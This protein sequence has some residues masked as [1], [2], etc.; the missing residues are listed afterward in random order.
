MFLFPRRNQPA[1]VLVAALVGTAVLGTAAR[2]DAQPINPQ[3]FKKK[4]EAARKEA[5]VVARARVLATACT[6]AAAGKGGP[7]TLQVALHLLDSEKGPAKKG[8][9]LVVTHKVRPPAGPGP[10][11]YGYMS[12]LRQFPFTPG[13]QGDV[14][15]RWD[16][17]RRAYVVVAGWVETPNNAPIPLE[18]GKAYVA[19]D[20]PAKK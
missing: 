3:V 6:E 12:A 8:D 15:L 5:E 4:F 14:A 19:G 18:A 13:V 17:E 7:V 11:A 2:T 9:V 16:N 10:R 20:K 1:P